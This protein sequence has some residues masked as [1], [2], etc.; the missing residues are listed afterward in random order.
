MERALRRHHEEKSVRRTPLP[1]VPVEIEPGPGGEDAADA[2]PTV[3]IQWG[4]F[5]DTLA[6]QGLT[7][8][9]VRRLLQ[10]PHGIPPGVVA[11]VNGFEVGPTHRLGAGDT[12][13][14]Q[15]E[16]GEKGAA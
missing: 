13:E 15:R 4:A 8:A 5:T 12:L 1:F 6:A 9:D 14:F 10:R 11:F 3:S 7:V 2:V 16:T